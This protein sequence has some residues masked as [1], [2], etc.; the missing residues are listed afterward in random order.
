MKRVLFAFVT[1]T[2]TAAAAPAAQA[3]SPITW[4]VSG[5]EGWTSAERDSTGISSDGLLRLARG[6]QPIQGLECLV[7][8]DLLPEGD[9]FLV[10]TG[11]GGVL[12]RVDRRGT[13][14]E[15]GKV[16]E[17][18]I[19][20]L[21]RDAA[22]AIL[23]G[24]SPDGTIY[25]LDA[26]GLRP[27]ADTPETYVWRIHADG[28]G[29]T[30][31][32]TGDA[33][34][35]YRLDRGGALSLVADLQATHVTGLEPM[36]EGFV[37][38]TGTPGRLVSIDARG[39][40]RTL[41][42]A[43]EP[44]LRAP[45]VD[46]S[47][48]VYFLAN[49]ADESGRLYRRLLSGAVEE[50]WRAPSG[51]A[52]D[53]ARDA[54]G[55]LWVT[56]GS[57]SGPG[58]LVRFVPGE[59][60]TWVEAAR[61]KEPQILRAHFVG[62]SAYLATGGQGRV[63]RL[64]GP[65]TAAGTAVSPVRD[66]GGPARWGA[67]TLDPLPGGSAVKVETRSGDTRVP[68]DAWSDWAAVSFPGDRGRVTSPPARFLQWRLTLTDPRAAVRGV[69][70]AYL[71]ANLGPRIRSV[72]VSALGAPLSKLPEGGPP[73]S[74]FQ[75]LP[76]GVRVEFQVPSNHS[77]ETPASDSEAVWARQYRALQW[78][79]EDPN[80]DSLRF[81][82]ELR[83][84]EETGWKTLKKDL[85]ASPWAWD[86]ATVPDGWY[87]LRVAASDRASNPPGLALSTSRE[88]DPF[89]VDNTPPRVT[90][91][92]VSG[93]ALAGTAEDAASPI[94]KIEIAVD[95]ESWCQVFPEDGIAD[96]PQETFSQKLTGLASGDHVVVVRAFD[97][98][99][100]PG[101]GRLQ[102]RSP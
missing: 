26:N 53:L 39:E 78:E 18:E 1:V 9:G 56:T 23:A 63:Y 72:L 33:G 17:P 55:A 32:A 50:I 66:A 62:E 90:G 88:S 37:L 75:V 48:V 2:W 42:D 12:Y 95:G 85:E 64:A 81:D 41:Y 83:A 47:G 3:V 20:A 93:E 86:S 38:T 73:G 91:L 61:V 24:A 44:E 100:N 71:P 22:G 27:V 97:A 92:R 11:D 29:G 52:Y 94:R 5:V 74:L 21:G 51:F 54:S 96:L 10:A 82:L 13:V 69:E 28:H 40:R 30:L 60:T 98:A 102:F 36:G 89:L 19:T 43:D 46:S 16:L 68:D 35:L 79:A 45:V 80:G 49:P 14:T 15:A 7:V 25:R 70:V 58:S 31:I 77:P 99:G 76:G 84:E 65:G 8:W 4:S 34:K 101:T 6:V 67:L 87:R 59:P 57:E